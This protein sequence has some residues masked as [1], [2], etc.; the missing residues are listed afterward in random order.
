MVKF[1]TEAFVLIMSFCS[2]RSFAA[3]EIRIT[4]GALAQKALV[5]TSGA[6]E[7]PLNFSLVFS[8]DCRRQHG[9]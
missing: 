4:D 2:Q 9:G 5:P 3:P 7:R 6:N 1:T 8:V